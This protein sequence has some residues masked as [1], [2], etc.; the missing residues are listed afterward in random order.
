MLLRL[1]TAHLVFAI[2]EK[3]QIA[4]ACTGLSS[5]CYMVFWTVMSTVRL[6]DRK[7]C[8][9]QDS[10]LLHMASKVVRSALTPDAQ[11]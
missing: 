10:Y 2:F 1:C 4:S 7:G 11:P 3:L 6:Q 8:H 5:Q 9:M